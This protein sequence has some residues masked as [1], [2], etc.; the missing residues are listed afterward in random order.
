MSKH[1]GLPANQHRAVLRFVN[2]Q[3]AEYGLEP[4]DAISR[5]R[6]RD[7]FGCPIR[8]SVGGD[9]VDA[10]CSLTHLKVRIKGK[11]KKRPLPP[12]IVRFIEQFDAGKFPELEI[13]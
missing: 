2:R 3:R 1:Q 6:R 12:S 10:L 8:N 9:V 11:L 4:V 13:K 5:G 7:F